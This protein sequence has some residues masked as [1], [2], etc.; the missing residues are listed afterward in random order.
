[1]FLYSRQS[2]HGFS[3]TL[4]CFCTP[5]NHCMVFLPHCHVLYFRQLLQCFLQDCSV[6][7][8]QAITAGFF[9]HNALFLYSWQSLQGFSTTLPIVCTSLDN[10][11]F[12]SRLP[13]FYTPGSHCRVYLPDFH[14]SVHLAITALFFSTTL[15]CF[16]TPGNHCRV[17]LPHCHVSVLQAITAGFF[18]HTAMFLYSRQS[19]QGFSTTLPCFCTPGNYCRFFLPHCHVSVL[20]AITA[21]FFYH[22]A[23]FLY[24]RQSLQGF[25][26]TLPSWTRE[27]TIELLSTTRPSWFTPTAPCSRTDPSGLYTM[28]SYSPLKNS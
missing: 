18:Y 19:L 20:Q 16:C 27:A 3:T 1:M 5:G 24:S 25:S 12:F 23:M 11:S 21:G 22:T 17:F 6:S 2:S 26:T 7:V 13:C 10:C 15:P 9:Y 8:L 14:V 4:P 28:S